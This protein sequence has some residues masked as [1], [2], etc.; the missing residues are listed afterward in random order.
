MLEVGV[1]RG[2]EHPRNL[3]KSP[4]AMCHGSLPLRY[5]IKTLGL[6]Y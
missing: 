2:W 6:P 4:G 5:H 3:R 1:Q